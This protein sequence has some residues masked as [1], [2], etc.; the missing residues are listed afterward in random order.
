MGARERFAPILGSTTLR[1]YSPDPLAWRRANSVSLQRV[2]APE[3]ASGQHCRQGLPTLTA[4]S[5]PQQASISGVISAVL[6]LQHLR[7]LVE[8]DSTSAPMINL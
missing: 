8:F 3:V 1:E 5:V 4:L 7:Q 2:E 6:A